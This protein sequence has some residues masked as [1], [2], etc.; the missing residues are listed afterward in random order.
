MWVI[1]FLW[2]KALYGRVTRRLLDFS[3]RGLGMRLSCDHV[4]MSI[5]GQNW[6][7]CTVSLGR[8]QFSRDQLDFLMFYG[9]RASWD[10]VL[11]MLKCFGITSIPQNLNCCHNVFWR[12]VHKTKPNTFYYLWLSHRYYITHYITMTELCNLIGARPVLPDPFSI[13]PKR[14]IVSWSQTTS[15]ATWE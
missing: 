7:V 11:I 10:K 14:T 2:D 13:F 3:E 1:E 9:T 12:V 8:D 5:C 6:K 4:L 15:L